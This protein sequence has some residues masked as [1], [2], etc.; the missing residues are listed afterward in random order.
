MEEEAP[1]PAAK[2]HEDEGLPVELVKPAAP[3]LP[4]ET[5]T[6]EVR[7]K[8]A[9]NSPDSQLDDETQ[10]FIAQSLTDVDLF[11]SYGLTQKA[12]G[13][14]EAILRLGLLSAEDKAAILGL[15]ALKVFDRIQVGGDNTGWQSTSS[16]ARK[17]SKTGVA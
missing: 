11:A 7:A 6:P 1:V 8:P 9:G 15:N 17:T 4:T 2:E 12:I 10:K 16:D 5:E 13:L 14:L 3:K